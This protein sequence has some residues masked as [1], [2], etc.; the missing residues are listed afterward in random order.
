[1][2]GKARKRV[3]RVSMMGKASRREG[4]EF[5]KL[6]YKNVTEVDDHCQIFPFLDSCNGTFRSSNIINHLEGIK[7]ILLC[8]NHNRS[9]DIRIIFF[10][11]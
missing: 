6:V 1:M 2:I 7:M 4:A 10:I 3:R 9:T 11:I 8:N 5:S